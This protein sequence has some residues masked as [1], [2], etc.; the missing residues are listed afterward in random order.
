MTT[1]ELRNIKILDVTEEAHTSNKK[2]QEEYMNQTRFQNT[3][4]PNQT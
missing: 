2:N 3:E 4:Q 1:D